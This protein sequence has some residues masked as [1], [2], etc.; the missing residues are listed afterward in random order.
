MTKKKIKPEQPN[1]HT[2]IGKYF[3]A[4]KVK[5]M[6][7]KDAQ[8]EAG[9]SGV[10]HGQRIEATKQYQELE[11]FYRDVI[12]EKMSLSD[13]ADEHI[14]VM[15]QDKDLSSKMGGIKL[16]LERIEP[17]SAP[18]KEMEIVSFKLK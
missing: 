3:V 6:T 9:F 14:K 4:R 2:R 7:K 5:N 8:I 18:Q 10:H 15:K 1:V 13:I 12:I 11:R 16:A 17:E